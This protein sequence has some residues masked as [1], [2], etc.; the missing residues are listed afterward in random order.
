MTKRAPVHSPFH[1]HDDD[2]YVP[3]LS[4]GSLP[5]PNPFLLP[6]WVPQSHV[7]SL[8]AGD[9]FEA[10][11]VLLPYG[12][13]T[14]RR[15]S[16]LGMDIGPVVASRYTM[17]MTFL[18]EP[19]SVP[20]WDVPGSRLLPHGARVEIPPAQTTV[21]KDIR[22]VVLPGGPATDPHHLRHALADSRRAPAP[23]PPARSRRRRGRRA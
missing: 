2:W 5:P 11:R 23:P 16:S 8:T 17:H 4:A 21:G 22:W 10:V 9:F 7:A 20:S 1:S 6:A 14:L 15:L 12:E 3:A 19:D 18:L 13:H